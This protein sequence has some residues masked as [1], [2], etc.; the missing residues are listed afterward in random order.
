M[1]KLSLGQ[2]IYAI[3]NIAFRHE[4]RPPSL[5]SP[6]PRMA[7]KDHLELLNLLALLLVTETSHDVAA[8]ALHRTADDKMTIFYSKNRPCDQD[9]TAYIVNLLSISMNPKTTITEKRQDLISLVIKTCKKKILRR[10][11]AIRN[12]LEIL[13]QESITNTQSLDPVETVVGSSSSAQQYDRYIRELVGPEMFPAIASLREFLANWFN[14][15]RKQFPK[16]E[17]FDYGAQA[18]LNLLLKTINISYYVVSNPQSKYIVQ[19]KLLVL[20]AKLADYRLAI[21]V[22]LLE[23]SKLNCIKSYSLH[24][25][26]VSRLSHL[27]TSNFLPIL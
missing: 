26:E 6:S 22:L 15:L 13:E 8:V 23:I 21:A 4:Y 20:I 24:L 18:N 25:V 11:Q 1:P 3:G 17:R 10:V 2:L 5:L 16:G 7:R 9:E 27:F 19:P 14:A 12:Q